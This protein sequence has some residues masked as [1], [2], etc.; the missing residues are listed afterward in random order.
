MIQKKLRTRLGNESLGS[1]GGLF[2]KTTKI[3]LSIVVMNGGRLCPTY[4]DV[5]VV[6]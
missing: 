3:V 5:Q 6:T 2:C 4:I 1:V